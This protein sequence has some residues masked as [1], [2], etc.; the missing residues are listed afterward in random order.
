ML[1][2]PKFVFDTY[3]LLSCARVRSQSDHAAADSMFLRH[4][5]QQDFIGDAI[6]PPSS[7]MRHEQELSSDDSNETVQPDVHHHSTLKGQFDGSKQSA[8]LSRPVLYLLALAPPF[9]FSQLYPSGFLAALDYAGTYGWVCF[10]LH[11]TRVD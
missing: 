8:P 5:C 7:P 1:N 10:W 3:E 4:N 9:A 6:S 11:G 2:E